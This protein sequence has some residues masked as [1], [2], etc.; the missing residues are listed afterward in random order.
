MRS[1]PHLGVFIPEPTAIF[2]MIVRRLPSLLTL[3]LVII[4]A[5]CGGDAATP[6]TSSEDSGANGDSP[7]VNSGSETPSTVEQLHRQLKAANPSYN[8]QG[9]FRLRQGQVV[10]AVLRNADVEDL[11]PLKGLPLRGID[12]YGNPITD[13][14]AL[15]GMPLQAVYLENTDVTDLSPLRDMSL[16]ALY[17]SN[18]PVEDLSPLQGMPL[19]E[20][21]LV[22]TPVTDLSPIAELPLR[23]LWLNDTPVEDIRPL[24]DSSIM[25][26]TLKGTQVSDISSVRTMPNLERLHIA[27]T[28]VSDLTP[29]EDVQLTRLV[30]TPSNIDR[31]MS[32]VRQMSSLQEIGTTFNAETRELM[33]PDQFWQQFDEGTLDSDS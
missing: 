11:T 6:S 20:L 5:A 17:L 14:Q 16:Q 21:N 27:H 4:L 19:Q 12:L 22:G 25:S 28:P 1:A 23:M 30:F 10:A 7:A 8:N 15:E 9:K 32:V 29:L 13:V 26:L 18:T 24:E 3:F 33:K 2:H 31:G